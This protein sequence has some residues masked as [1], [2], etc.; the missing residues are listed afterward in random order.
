[1][2]RIWYID[3][4]KSKDCPRLLGTRLGTPGRSSQHTSPYFRPNDDYTSLHRFN[5]YSNIPFQ[6]GT[7]KLYVPSLET[8][9]L[10]P[11]FP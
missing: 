3:Y 1:M 7:Y 11:R 4:E 10:N 2:K 9:K 6:A 8:N 5:N